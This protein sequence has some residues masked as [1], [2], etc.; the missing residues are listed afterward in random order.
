MTHMTVRDVRLHWPM[1]EKALANGEEIVVTRDAKPVA[2]LLPFVPSTPRVRS[3]FN[4]ELHFRRLKRFWTN[5]P[6]Q[7]STDEWLARDRS[8][9]TQ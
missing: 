3:P 8:D 6:T 1:A 9:T 5:Q 2:R 4:P 7:P